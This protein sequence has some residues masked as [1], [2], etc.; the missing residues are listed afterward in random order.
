[1]VGSACHLL[2]STADAESPS[3]HVHISYIPDHT[4]M[5]GH[6]IA[7][8]NSGIVD[9]VGL[10]GDSVRHLCGIGKNRRL[11]ILKLYRI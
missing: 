5:D 2:R 9:V 10:S 3:I 7:A 6:G 8:R 4:Y 11:C 1:M